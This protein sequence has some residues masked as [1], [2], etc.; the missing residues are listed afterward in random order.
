MRRPVGFVLAAVAVLLLGATAVTYSKYQKSQ[1]DFAQAT[2]NQEQMRQ[3]YENAVGEIVAIQD[4]LNAIVLGEDQVSTARNDVEVNE[5]G[6]LHDNVQA[7]LAELKGAIERTKDR[8]EELDHR[9][10]RSGVKIAGM[11]KMIANLKQSVSEKEVRISE[12]NGQVDT[13][14]TRVTGLTTDVETKQAELQA[15]QDELMARQQE[16]ATIFYTMGTKKELSKSGVLESKGGVLGLG[17]SPKLTGHY[18]QSRFT[19]LNTDQENT[20]RIPYE[21]AQ[22]LSAQPAGSYSI[23]PVSKESAELHI[24]NAAE[25]RKVKHLVIVKA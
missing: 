24:L 16:L 18:D 9:L 20:I 11:E 2:A 22:V 23:T 3:R 13:L 10:K 5:P 6:T 15:K 14:Q 21:K 17:K 19:A 4:S 1:S 7:R 25:F 12:L 8:I